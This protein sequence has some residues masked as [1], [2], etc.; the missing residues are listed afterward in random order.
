MW[1]V[2]IVD[3]SLEVEEVD[4]KALV[5]APDNIKSAMSNP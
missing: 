2:V 1:V 5:P 3:L 4:M